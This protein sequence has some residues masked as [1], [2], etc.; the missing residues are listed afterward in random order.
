VWDWRLWQWCSWSFRF[1]V[2]WHYVLVWPLSDIL[3][4][5]SALL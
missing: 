4:D 2:M 3:K 5:S 1:S